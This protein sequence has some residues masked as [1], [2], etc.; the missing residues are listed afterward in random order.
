[1]A[2]YCCILA[3]ESILY[4]SVD[5]SIPFHVLHFTIYC[6]NLC[7]D[8]CTHVCTTVHVAC[9]PLSV[10]FARLSGGYIHVYTCVHVL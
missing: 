4:S 7:L 10:L 9:L 5:R 3:G 2:V 6:K 8:V 1:M